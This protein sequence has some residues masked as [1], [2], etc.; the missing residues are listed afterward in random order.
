MTTVPALSL[1]EL[2]A[3]LASESRTLLALERVL[4]TLKEPAG[5][6][7]FDSG[8]IW[9]RVAARRPRPGSDEVRAAFHRIYAD[10]A[11]AVHAFVR[12]RVGA[13]EAEELTAETFYRAYGSFHRW[14]DRGIPVRA[15]LLRIAYNQVV[16]RA[17]KAMPVPVADFDQHPPATTGQEEQMD[18]R[19]EAGAALEALSSLPAS[20][21]TVLEL[22]HLQ[23]LS[24]PETATVMGLSE[25]ATR[26]LTYRA[27]QGLRRAYAK[28]AAIAD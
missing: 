16:G 14:Q 20:H 19:L 24:V 23:E 4:A 5:S 10:N 9:D 11:E 27:M 8:G 6:A 21:R 17:R 7:A 13:A 12:R 22:R 28:G 1:E 2:R 18:R 15:W 25:E 26:A 3:G